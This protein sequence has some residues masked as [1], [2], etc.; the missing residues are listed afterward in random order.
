M[1]ATWAPPLAIFTSSVSFETRK[2]KSFNCFHYIIESSKCHGDDVKRRHRDA[3]CF[4][5]KNNVMWWTMLGARRSV[6]L[7]TNDDDNAQRLLDGVNL[8]SFSWHGLEWYNKRLLGRHDDE[9]QPGIFIVIL[10]M[11]R[12]CRRCCLE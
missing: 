10:T 12:N 7:M 2:V 5:Y 6:Y 4:V 8:C 3:Y 9:C 11:V 1:W